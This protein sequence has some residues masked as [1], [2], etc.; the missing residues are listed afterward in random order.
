MMFLP[1]RGRTADTA[2]ALAVTGSFQC[3]YDASDHPLGRRMTL[4]LPR[5]GPWP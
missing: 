3:V 2:R 5:L 4:K 1:G